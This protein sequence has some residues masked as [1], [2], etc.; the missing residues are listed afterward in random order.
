ME[1]SELESIVREQERRAGKASPFYMA[2][3][4]M[5]RSWMKNGQTWGWEPEH[6]EWSRQ[7]M[8]LHLTRHERPAGTIMMTEWCR[9]SRKSTLGGAYVVTALLRNP[10]ERIL[11]DSDTLPNAIRKLAPIREAFENGYFQEL[12]GDLRG[13]IWRAETIR[14]KRRIT[15]ASDNSVTASGTETSKTSQHYTIV[16]PDD[17]QTKENSG[18]A[19]ALDKVFRDWGL[20]PSLMVLQQNEAGRLEGPMIVPLGTPWAENDLFQKID[21][22]AAADEKFGR[23]RRIYKSRKG[24]FRKYIDA[25]GEEQDNEQEPMFPRA[26]TL[27]MIA[28][29]RNSMVDRDFALQYCLKRLN[30]EKQMFH[31]DMFIEHA[32]TR[33]NLEQMHV[34]VQIDPAGLAINPDGKVGGYKKSDDNVVSVVA[35]DDLA[36]LYVL[37]YTAEKMDRDTLLEHVKRVNREY[38]GPWLKGTS[39]EKRFKQHELAAWLKKEAAEPDRGNPVRINWLEIKQDDRTKEARISALQPY[40]K[41]RKIRVR[42]GM[43][44]LLD[45]F[46]R[47]PAPAVHDDIPDAIAQVLDVMTVPGHKTQA[48]IWGSLEWRNNQIK[49]GADPDRL[50]TREDVRT[51][52]TVMKLKARMKKRRGPTDP[53]YLRL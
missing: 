14:I 9:D 44:K 1:R 53:G 35:V 43:V 38:A 21:D 32:L 24:C 10:D 33:L 5:G 17:K 26:L 30:P 42:S 49:A 23:P 3:Y 28:V 27:E 46:I 40:A 12:Y 29:K 4:I 7:I 52:R 6:A 45:Q 15:G 34:Y 25:K 19:E 18:S 31:R 22:E 51:W 50:P 13:E 20:Y 37:E 2:K 39:I 11:L 48:E 41:N 8:G 47:Y 36:N 16:V